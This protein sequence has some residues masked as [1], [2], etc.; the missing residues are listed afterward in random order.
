MESLYGSIH[1]ILRQAG[2]NPLRLRRNIVSPPMIGN[3]SVKIVGRRRPERDQVEKLIKEDR[4]RKAHDIAQEVGLIDSMGYEKAVDY[5]RRVRKEMKRNGDLPRREY[6][7]ASDSERMEDMDKLFELRHGK[8]VSKKVTQSMLML[9]CYYRLRSEDD[10]IH[11]MAI[12]DTYA[13]NKDLKNPLD[14]SDA[15]E[16][17][18]YA[19]EK[20]MESRDP[21]KNEAKKAMGYPGAGLN[22]SSKTLIDLLEITDEE[23]QHMKSIERG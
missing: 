14:M 7:Q 6:I 2:V 12:D 10:D 4:R 13:K 23:L 20:Y 11:I 22:Y 1:T 16:L 19:L 18:K 3:W 9:N 8:R 15:I 21:E 5:V 17:C